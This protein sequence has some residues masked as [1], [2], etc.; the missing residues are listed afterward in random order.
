M[1]MSVTLTTAFLL[2]TGIAQAAWVVDG[3]RSTVSFVSTKAINVA[4]V[5][6]FGE[7]SG[8]MD[9]NGEVSVSIGLASVDTGIEIRD[10]RMREMLFE[11]GEYSAATISAK[12]DA[13][14]VD[15][16]SPGESV[17]MVVEGIL[18]LHGESRPL[19]L[20]IVVARTG[21]A[22]LLVTSRK[23]VVINAPQFNLGEGVEALRAIAGL[24]SISL[25]VPVSFVLALDQ[26]D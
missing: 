2:L 7:L 10:D 22:G 19:I 23:P 3:E 13:D 1:K 24:P 20:E 4:E 9:A 17:D 8:G 26:G 5:H 18:E 6:R 14:Q 12:V 11:T 16:L 25:A 21:E 15:A